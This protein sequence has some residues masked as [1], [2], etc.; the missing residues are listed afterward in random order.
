MCMKIAVALILIAAVGTFLLTGPGEHVTSYVTYEPHPNISFIEPTPNQGDILNAL[1]ADIKVRADFPL[2]SAL[3]EWN[4]VNE[5][6][7]GADQEWEISKP[8]TGEFTFR[9]HGITNNGT[10]STEARIINLFYLTIA[11]IDNIN[12][13]EDSFLDSVNLLPLVNSPTAE[14]SA[15]A[16]SLVACSTTDDILLCIPNQDESG[17]TK[18]T[19][20][21]E[22]NGVSA[23]TSF[24][25]TI[26]PVND[27]PIIKVPLEDEEFSTNEYLKIHLDDHFAD[28]DSN[29][30][31]TYKFFY[32]NGDTA[33]DQFSTELKDNELQ[34]KPKS[35]AGNTYLLTITASDE[36]SKVS[37]TARLDIESNNPPEIRSSA[38]SLNMASDEIRAV[39]LL[40]YFF[41]VDT[42]EDYNKFRIG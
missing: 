10:I 41:D 21:A 28:I 14:L 32:Q 15:E 36:S 38:T 1:R 24:Y 20:T 42:V 35:M 29:I 30:D 3:L 8:G 6:M 34:I 37:D 27:P 25:I 33:D 22:E 39:D 7:D 12:G 26:N 4:G 40:D 17:T 31:Y 2:Q 16:E 19:V 5:S 13:D 18:V 9:V 23:F 11:A